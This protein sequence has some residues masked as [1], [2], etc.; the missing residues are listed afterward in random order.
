MQ[1]NL[2]E[3][4]ESAEAMYYQIIESKHLTDEIR[5]I[6][7][8][9]PIEKHDTEEV[10]DI[11]DEFDKNSTSQPKTISTLDEEELCEISMQ[12]SYN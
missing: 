9:D 11:D 5:I 12:F 3:C 8:E 1:I 10:S 4:L 6:I 7:G 2:K